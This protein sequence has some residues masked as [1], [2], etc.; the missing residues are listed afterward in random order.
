MGGT[1]SKDESLNLKY[2]VEVDDPKTSLF[3]NINIHRNRLL[4]N[5]ITHQYIEEYHL[6]FVSHDDFQDY[7]S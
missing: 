2:W 7:L 6:H 5:T 4:L 3:P 1:V